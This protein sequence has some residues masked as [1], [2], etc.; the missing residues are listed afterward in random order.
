MR[1]ENILTKS[2]LYLSYPIWWAVSKSPLEGA[3]TTLHCASSPSIEKQGGK[4]FSDCEPK[5]PSY[6]SKDLAQKL[7]DVS[8]KL[9][10]LEN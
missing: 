9:V 5:E 6:T 8:E 4:Y 1:H 7:W 10:G 3:Q 2:L